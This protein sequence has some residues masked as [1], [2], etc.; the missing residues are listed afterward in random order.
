M[1]PLRVSASHGLAIVILRDLIHADTDIRMDLQFRGGMDSLQLFARSK[2]DVAGFH[3]PEGTLGQRLAPRY[4]RWLNPETDNLIHV[5]RRRQG[6]MTVPGNPKQL[7]SIAGLVAGDVR[8]VNRQRGSGTRLLLDLLL[9]E[10]GLAP[11]QIQGYHTEEFTHLAVAAL[12]ASGAAD[13][14][15]GIEAAAGRF[16]L[17]FIPIVEENYLFAVKSAN[18]ANPAVSTLI[19]MLGHTGFR[20][21]IA[22]LPGYDASR[23]AMRISVDAI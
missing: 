7:Q 8:F 13:A 18:L 2:C 3:V 1:P 16:G 15:F 11:D 17:G 9:E 10:A 5:V 14:G 6:L 4:Q 23:S 22:A 12:V 20:E 21:K 19:E